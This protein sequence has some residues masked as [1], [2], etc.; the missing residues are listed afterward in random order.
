MKKAFS[1]FLL[2]ILSLIYFFAGYLLGFYK[3]TISAYKD[4]ANQ[5]NELFEDKDS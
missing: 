3:G 4:G 2:I 1:Y 5:I